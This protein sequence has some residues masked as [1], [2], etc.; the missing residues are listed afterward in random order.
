MT[1]DSIIND[2]LY[3][4]SCN[5]NIEKV[6]ELLN[7]NANCNYYYKD[8]NTP[9]IGAVINNQIAIIEVL[10]FAGANVNAKNNLSYQTALHK[11]VQNKNIDIVKELINNNASIHVRDICM[12]SPLYS[13]YHNN[14]TEII[15]LLLSKGAELND[16]ESQLLGKPIYQKPYSYYNHKPNCECGE[17][18]DCGVLWCGCIDTC[19]N[20]CGLK[21]N[22][23]DDIY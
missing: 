20:R 12:K 5:G 19:R 9:L 17:K 21:E 6:L 13:A 14:N 3:L 15:N 1:K 7:T 18:K 10:I 23:L 2:N 4:E 22:D 8:G 11:A 16:E